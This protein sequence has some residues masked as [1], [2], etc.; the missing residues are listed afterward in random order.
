[1]DF[2]NKDGTTERFKMNRQR[3][4]H[5]ITQYLS[6]GITIHIDDGKWDMSTLSDADADCLLQWTLF[7]ELRYEV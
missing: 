5:A 2:I 6:D 7:G 3:L 1:M 4:L